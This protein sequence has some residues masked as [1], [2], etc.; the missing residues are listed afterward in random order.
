MLIVVG[1]FF[2]AVIALV[3]FFFDSSFG[4]SDFV[5][6]QGVVD[7]LSGVI[8]REKLENGTFYD[9]GSCRGSF[10]KKV[11]KAFPTLNVHG[12]DNSRI[13]TVCAR[14]RGIFLKNLIFTKGDIFGADVFLADIVYLYLPQ[15]LMPALQEKLQKELKPGTVVISASVSFPS[16]QPSQVYD[17]PE[18]G[19]KVPKL[20][21]YRK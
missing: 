16:W 5:S 4:G 11:A 12:I 17:L 18:Q 13:R 10:A 20:F 6:H 14:V 1:L 2:L 8:R 9:L 15:E 3:I 7:A 19:L 21:V